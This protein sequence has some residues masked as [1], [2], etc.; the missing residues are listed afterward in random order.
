M[1][2]CSWKTNLSSPQVSKSEN[3]L[4]KKQ[5]TGV[6]PSCRK[7]KAQIDHP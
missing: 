7:V 4:G 3:K 6:S 5:G 1:L 2:E